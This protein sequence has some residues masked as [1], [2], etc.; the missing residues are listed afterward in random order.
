M[1]AV[2][3]D[4]VIQGRGTSEPMWRQWLS[5]TDLHRASVEDLL[6]RDTR[7][8]VVAPHPDDEVL[9]CGALL[10]THAARDGRC[11]VVAVTD[12]E[13][14]HGLSSP[15]G[16]RRLAA[17]RRAESESGLRLLGLH[18][19]AIYRLGLPDARV[20]AHA[21][22][23]LA[24]L[25]A[26]LDVDDVVVTTW[27]FDGHP[28]HEATGLAAAQACRAAGCRLLEAP[29]WMWHWAVP[30]DARVP[31]HRLSRV[32]VALHAS[33]SKQAALARHVSQL[34]RWGAGQGPIL[35]T[36]MVE[37]AARRS[38]YFFLNE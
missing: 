35:D 22:R 32:S 21:D 10:A 31:W 8:V 1:G 38:E 18:R 28:D 24:H 30:D 6:D 11:A 26:L 9:A 27:R 12:G 2:T 7:L 19:A 4:R 16:T 14:S 33:A 3:A 15:D 29:V 36:T 25:H 13:A 20:G 37:R 23:L 17:K 5:A 34:S